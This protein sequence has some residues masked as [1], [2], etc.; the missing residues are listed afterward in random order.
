MRLRRSGTSTAATWRGASLG[1]IKREPEANHAPTAEGV[2]AWSYQVVRNILTNEKYCGD[3]LLFKARTLNCISKKAV[4]NNGE[5][6]MVY[7]EN[8]HE[9]IVPR[10]YSS[11]SRRRWPAGPASE[12]SCSA[13][14]ERSRANTPANMLSLSCWCA[15]SAALFDQLAELEREAERQTLQTARLKELEEWLAQQPDV[16]TEYDDSV[17]RRLV[18]QITVVDAGTIRVKL[19]D[20]DVEIE[21]EMC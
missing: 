17:T 12:R 3:T 13:T 11:G 14:A 2:A 10:W 20:T 9:G 19:K 4:K 16:L 1:D 18:A 21:Q 6:P 15:E 7:I 8:N 5:W